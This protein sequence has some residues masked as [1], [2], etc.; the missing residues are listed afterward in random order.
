MAAPVTRLDNLSSIILSQVKTI[1]G[2]NNV[3]EGK[4][5]FEEDE[6]FEKI[7]R[8]QVEQTTGYLHY[9]LAARHARSQT[10]TGTAIY[11]GV[12][13]IHLKNKTT[14]CRAM[15]NL[16]ENVLNVLLEEFK[17]V[18]CGCRPIEGGYTEHLKTGELAKYDEIVQ[19]DFSATYLVPPTAGDEDP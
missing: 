9:W 12:C 10:E 6:N 5:R 19:Y 11:H 18:D 7:V 3:F 15:F 1:L 13:T 17:F 2:N 14:D 8:T 4:V 16:F